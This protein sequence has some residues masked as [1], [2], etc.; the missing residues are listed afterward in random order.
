MKIRKRPAKPFEPSCRLCIL[1]AMAEMTTR[2]KL[3]ILIA[4]V[5]PLMLAPGPAGG[6]GKSGAGQDQARKGTSVRTEFGKALFQRLDANHDSTVTKDEFTAG[7]TVLFEKVDADDNGSV[8]KGEAAK[9]REAMAGA[10]KEKGRTKALEHFGKMDTNGDGALSSGEWKG[11]PEGFAK[12]DAD[13]NGSVSKDEFLGGLSKL[14]GAI[15]DRWQAGGIS[16]AMWKRA[17]TNNDG[18]I[19]TDE[20]NASVA[21][22]FTKLDR[23]GDGVLS[24]ADRSQGGAGP[25]QPGNH[26]E[27][28][29]PANPPKPPSLP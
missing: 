17:D 25:P 20:W 2:S 14:A 1:E 5:I 16:E 7:F 18:A 4:A 19:S 26:K 8:S 15:K 9:A 3:A 10:I 29:P 11:R 6:P 22:L 24:A 13:H 21:N 28:S 12:L 23:N 27:G